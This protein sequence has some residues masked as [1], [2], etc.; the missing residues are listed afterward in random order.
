MLTKPLRH[1]TSCEEF[2]GHFEGELSKKQHCAG[3]YRSLTTVA[4]KP[5]FILSKYYFLLFQ[6]P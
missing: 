3:Y 6:V 4:H 5:S 2:E 1:V